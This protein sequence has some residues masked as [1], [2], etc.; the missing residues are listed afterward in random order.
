MSR[1]SARFAPG[2][3]A[4]LLAAAAPAAVRAAGVEQAEPPQTIAAIPLDAAATGFGLVMPAHAEVLRETPLRPAPL[5]DPD[6]SP[7]GPSSAALSAQ[8]DP[9]LEPGIF[10]PRAHFAGDGY[11]AG[12][13]IESD[14]NHRHSTG[15]GMNL[16]I[17]MQ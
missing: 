17:P 16:S 12:S 3:L 1:R 6:V 10:N 2:L 7:P 8:A 4:A 13:S 14:Q 11:S 15:G 5:P 9:S